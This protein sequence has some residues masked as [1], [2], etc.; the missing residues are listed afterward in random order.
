MVHSVFGV[1]PLLVLRPTGPITA[2]I[3]KL[4]GAADALNLDFYAYLS[5]TGAC[6]GVLMVFVS[7]TELSR[8]VK[9]LTPFTH[10]IFACFV[11]SIYVVDGVSELFFSRGSP[12]GTH[13]TIEAFGL[14][15]LTANLAVL[16]FGLAMWLHQA[17]RWTTLSSAMRAFL[18]DYNVTLAVVLTT[19][20]S[21]SGSAAVDQWVERI[22][23]P[24]E[25]SPTCHYEPHV[26]ETLAISGVHTLPSTLP[27]RLCV[28]V[29]AAVVGDH[30]PWMVSMASFANDKLKL[31][32]VAF[33]SAIPITFFFYVKLTSQHNI[34]CPAAFL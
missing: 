29:S 6:I 18:V 9:M 14:W 22:E 24:S 20:I 34:C 4:S 5:A 25:I 26:S 7:A 13:E 21:Y 31:W 3:I 12:Q 19:A 23:L 30:R 28:G 10:D 8:H 11:C 2:I 33:L 15:L 1:Q 27:H 17:G 32:F 16:T